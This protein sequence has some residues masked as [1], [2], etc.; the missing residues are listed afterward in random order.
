MDVKLKNDLYKQIMV[1]PLDTD[2]PEWYRK[3]VSAPGPQFDRAIKK[4]DASI[5]FREINHNVYVIF[6]FYTAEGYV[7]FNLTWM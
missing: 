4:Y 2:Q 7:R 1:L 5:G 6:S 3:F